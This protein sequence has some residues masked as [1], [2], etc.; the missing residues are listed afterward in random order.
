MMP[1]EPVHPA[2]E[3]SDTAEVITP[4][5]SLT[6]CLRLP[7]GL[8]TPIPNSVGIFVLSPDLGDKNQKAKFSDTKV[9]Y[10]CLT[11]MSVLL[12]FY[13]FRV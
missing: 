5:A 7:T 13:F 4:A 12:K 11:P 9:S 8:L 10:F 6:D 2:P 1:S 3:H